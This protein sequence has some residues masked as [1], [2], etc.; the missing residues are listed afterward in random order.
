MP[1]TCEPF[2]SPTISIGLDA[3]NALDGTAPYFYRITG[4]ANTFTEF[5][6]TTLPL[7]IA[8]NEGTFNVELTD[9]SRCNVISLPITLQEVKRPEATIAGNDAYSCNTPEELVTVT[10]SNAVTGEQYL[11]LIHI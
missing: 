9:A 10:I 8:A 6:A 2:R 3:V 11:S 5:N 7:E 4:L 1:G